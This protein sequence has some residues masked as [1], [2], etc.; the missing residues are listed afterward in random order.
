MTRSPEI[1]LLAIGETLIWALIYYVFPALLL[2]WEQDLGWSK[3]DLT[4]AIALAVLVSAV[5]SPLAG[6]IID[7]GHGPLLLGGSAALGGLGLILLSMVTE[8]WQFQAIWVVMGLAMAGCLYEPC[9]ALVTRV[10]RGN[11]KQAII[12]ITLAAGFA[13]TISFPTTYSLVEAVGWRSTCLIFAA[14][15]LGVVTPILWYGGRLLE[16]N[17]VATASGPD[18]EVTERSFLKRPAFWFLAIGF[19]FIATT[20]GATIQHM[21][22]ILNERGLSQE[23]AVL[24]AS[25]VGPMQVAGRL[26]MMASERYLSH[27]GVAIAAFLMMGLA[28]VCLLFSGL[29]PA[30]VSGFVL[31]FGSAYGTVSILRP[32][33]AR[34]I[35]GN[36]RFGAKSGALALPY[37][38]GSALA[39]FIGSLLWELGGY[40]LMILILMALIA[41]GTA[42]YLVAHYLA[43]ATSSPET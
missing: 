3:A 35:L 7:K 9:F 25:F 20:H 33:L 11:A 10:R 14:V 17:Y 21:L 8:L 37:L 32:L 22:P 2:T 4:A 28:N 40:D 5:A 24:A 23:M 6:R 36:E 34:D 27:H 31:L 16:A 19:A 13:S 26:A 30:F 39:P 41:L 12:L 38:A 15:V 29:S 42:F 18:E 1:L 43:G